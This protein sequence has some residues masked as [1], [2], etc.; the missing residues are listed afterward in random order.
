ML[1]VH[2][3]HVQ[4]LSIDNH[5]H[6]GFMGSTNNNIWSTSVH[7]SKNACLFSNSLYVWDYLNINFIENKTYKGNA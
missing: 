3:Y 6:N 7:I 2:A 5:L 1:N 4:N